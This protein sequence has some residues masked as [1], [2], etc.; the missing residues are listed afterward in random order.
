MTQGR[1]SEEPPPVV[2]V[3]DDLP[4]NLRQLCE[5]LERSGY[6]VMP[7]QDGMSALN[8]ARTSPPDLI[9]L[10]VRMPG[11]D[12]FEVCGCL[13]K[14]AALKDIPVIF[15]SALGDTADKIK[16][17]QAGGVDYITK[18]FQHEEVL[19]RVKAH[20]GLM[21]CMVSLQR[22]R[23]ML[24]ERVRQRTADLEQASATLRES[25]EMFRT[26]ADFTYDW[27]YWIGPDNRLVWVSPSSELV[28][29]YTAE[30]FV[31][32]PD[33]LRRIVHPEDRAIFDKHS[34]ASEA[35]SNAACNMDFRIVHLS[36]KHVWINHHCVAIARDDGTPLGRRASNRD[37]TDRKQ[38]EDKLT[39]ELAINKAMSELSGALI[40]KATTFPDI[41]DTTLYFS[42][43][44][45]GS[46]HGFVGVI[47][48]RTGDLVCYTLT[49]MMGKECR[50]EE[51][52]ARVTF[53]PGPDGRYPSLWGQAL[54]SCCPFYT[55]APAA[56]PS[57]TGIPGGHIH[58]R[59]FLAVPAL[60]G[61]MLI[62]LIALANTPDGYTDR[63]MEAVSH[64]AGLYAVA[65]DRQR[66]MEA[67][68]TGER[69]IRGLFNAA[70]DS[71]L[72]IDATG[73]ILAVNEWGAKRRGLEP[74]D[75]VGNNLDDF[76]P[77][78]IA[79][80][81][82]EGMKESAR[83][84]HCVDSEEIHEGRWY[85]VRIFPILDDAGKAVQFAIFSRDVTEKVMAEKA[86][87][88]ALA[89]AKEL[90]VKA[91]A[92]NKAK[93]EFLANMSHEIRTPLNG[94]MGMLQ[95]LQDTPLSGEQS[96][97][98]LHAI[99]A[100][101]RLTR[102]LSDILDLSAIESG[103]LAI[104][105]APFDIHEISRSI[106][107]LFALEAG[108]KG[109]TLTC[110]IDH[111]MPS[112][113][114]GDE[115]R[116]RQILFNLVG[117]AV[118]F[119]ARGG[120]EIG[121][122]PVSPPGEL[123]CRVLFS[124]TDTGIG[125]PDDRLSDIFEPFTQVEGSYLR[126]Y[127]GGGLGLAIVRRL[128]RL[129][130]G[131][132]CIES[133]EGAGTSA[134]VV[135]PFGARTQSRGMVDIAAGAESA[136]GGGRARILLVEDEAVNLLSM[137]ILLERAGYAVTTARDGRQALECLRQGDFELIVMD[138]QM[139][140]MDGVEATR[141]IRGSPEFTARSHIPIIALTAYAMDGDRERFLAAGM[142]DYIAK[143]VD[144]AALKDVIMR[145]TAKS[146]G[147]TI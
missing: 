55:N 143:P 136:R 6:R 146:R 102:L 86:L 108:A 97:Y 92:A 81:R 40:A 24:G 106:N 103:R 124:I 9:L 32:D 126:R 85:H 15:I 130:G 48:P 131:E 34:R 99:M 140:V 87:R 31:S 129:M 73:A 83:T 53:P 62:G 12:G 141:I 27:E 88:D 69:Q 57:S 122:A 26:V 50:V 117:N 109:L 60:I 138:V 5:I 82:R 134:H 75:M 25:E 145:A 78:D 128:T 58:L 147:A 118:K 93:S 100:S 137:N 28:T 30:A 125:I 123:P 35:D 11:M 36:G 113:L 44:L 90:A 19:A 94:I 38:A 116:L 16:G 10:D 21:R 64:L 107:D 4:A 112:E 51:G 22:S 105:A 89:Q 96:E 18:P 66:T 111:G 71:V 13:K 63:N 76:L 115:A 29:G 3:V 80:C 74:Q 59:N 7:A 119:T 39:V 54:N 23:D 68:W 17:F 77:P 65:I 14:E 70:T 142:D 79:A 120:V 139:P 95:V 110:R 8:A 56:H 101:K 20:L 61:D 98:L 84:G 41:A 2:L 72:L 127:Q 46:V 45:T 52:Q 133:E 1:E 37:I 121:I 104:L 132:I 135:L 67:L 42:K 47:D 144:M 49:P 114:V 33:L 91:E 43:L